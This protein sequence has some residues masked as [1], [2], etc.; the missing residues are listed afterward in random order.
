MVDCK[1]MEFNIGQW[2]KQAREKANKSQEQLALDLGYKGKGT[3]SAWEKN[4]NAV[5]FDKML[6]ISKITG[7]PLPYA[8]NGS[9]SVIVSD[10]DD[11]P[12][13]LKLYDVAASCG[14]GHF[15]G[16]YP[17]L[18]RTISLTEDAALELFGTANLKDVQMIP[19]DGDSMEPTIPA[20]SICFIK[21][22]IDSI[23]SS[24]IYLFTFQGATFMKRLFLGRGNIIHVS[25]DNRFY[26]KGD[27]T[28]NPDEI[29]DLVIHGKLW[30]AMSLDMINLG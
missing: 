17:D 22:N 10:P 21:T 24:G 19:P 9:P 18:I 27:F 11:G 28:I 23:S 25:S 7:L 4:T 13:K 26:E 6:E 15:N 5:P 12:I 30:K 14:S 16:N 1:N 20:K 3:V 8:S 2:V 29:H